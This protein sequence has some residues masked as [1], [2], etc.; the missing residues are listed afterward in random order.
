MGR[1]LEGKWKIDDTLGH[2]MPFHVF[3]VPNVIIREL[4][5][6]IPFEYKTKSESYI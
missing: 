5:C 3:F 6:K 2:K 4:L 1:Y